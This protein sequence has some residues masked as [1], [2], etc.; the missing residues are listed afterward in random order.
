MNITK[1]SSGSYQIR[2]MRNG[3]RYSVTVPFKP[4]T[5]EAQRIIDEKIDNYVEKISSLDVAMSKYIEA[6]SN[7]LSPSTLRAYDS[8]RRS[9]P[10]WFAKKDITEI[11]NYTLQK[12]INE[13]SVDHNPK[14]VSNCY[15]FCTAV[16][17]F[18]IPDS[19]VRATVPQ[20]VRKERYT[21]S[22]DDIKALFEYSKDSE[23]YVA[24]RLASMSLRRSE[25][26]AL[27]LEDLDE[28]DNLTINKA[29]VQDKNKEWIIKPTP[30]TDASNRTIV[31]PH[32]IA[33]RIREQGYIYKYNP[34]SIDKYLRQTLPKL[35]IPFFSLHKM[36][37]FFCSYAH[38]LGYTDQTIQEIGG[39]ATPSVLRSVYRHAMNKDE[40]KKNIAS[41]F[42]L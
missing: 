39:W 25:L 30:K 17:R 32:D 27:T 7:V 29:M 3:K 35:G 26:L 14:S 38:D 36:R 16:I 24:L 13:L 42:N 2:E 37:H 10:E 31:L 12:Y 18:F 11:D 34:N 6:K 1:L 21:P 15:G 20:K 4:G 9:L 22:V 8:M 23:Y 5:K 40:A 19:T 28:N 41:D 33:E